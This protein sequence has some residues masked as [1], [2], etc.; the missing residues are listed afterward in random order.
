ML[1]RLI[2]FLARCHQ[3]EF[4]VVF[5][6]EPSGYGAVVRFACLNCDRQS[7]ETRLSH[8]QTA[9]GKSASF[10]HK[11]LQVWLGLGFGESQYHQFFRTLNIDHYS[12]AVV[13][14]NQR[15]LADHTDDKWRSVQQEVT[16]RIRAQF[17][18]GSAY[19]T[20]FTYDFRRHAPSGLSILLH[21]QSKKIVI[22]ETLFRTTSSQAM[23]YEGAEKL[24]ESAKHLGLKVTH[25]IKDAH[26]T[27]FH[28]FSGD[29]FFAG[30]LEV[31]D[32]NH[33]GKQVKSGLESVRRGL[34]QHGRPN[35]LP[36][37]LPRKTKSYFFY[38]LRE[39]GGTREVDCKN[40]QNEWMK[41][42]RHLQGLAGHDK[43][44]KP[45]HGCDRA[46][47]QTR[48]SGDASARIFAFFT[49]W[50]SEI[51]TRRLYFGWN[52]AALDSFHHELLVYR[53]KIHYWKDFMK[54]R[55]KLAMI[56]HNIG[57]TDFIN[58]LSAL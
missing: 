28:A 18:G 15:R 49:M 31:R 56:R 33:S 23:E 26:N 29:Q 25:V 3:H 46:F 2:A 32:T 16:E 4:G 6:A 39:Y 17:R 5:T 13:Y 57:H 1:S 54:T 7:S 9:D 50:S 10:N 43:E 37:D 47:G 48:V 36:A 12:H 52:C 27:T 35:P 19:V 42:Q 38:V 58:W 40:V 30:V 41:G 8:R 34:G 11:V 22:G 20:D 21:H 24:A 44:C 53:D 14:A 51:R 55:H 45:G